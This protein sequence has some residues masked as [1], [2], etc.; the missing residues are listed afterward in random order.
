[1]FEK[2]KLINWKQPKFALP[3]I[4]YPLLLIA[5]FFILRFF[6]IEK[7]ETSVTVLETKD[8]LNTTLPEA[9]IKG[10]GV[11]DKFDAMMNEYGKISDLTAVD[12]I[13]REQASTASYE[14]KYTDAEAAVLENGSKEQKEALRQLRELRAQMEQQNNRSTGQGTGIADEMSEDEDAT[15]AELNDRLSGGTAVQEKPMTP[16]ERVRAAKAAKD[17]E[18]RAKMIAQN[19]DKV[20]IN[21]NA[22]TEINDQTAL[23]EVAKVEVP[24]SNHFNTIGKNEP[25]NRLI[26]AMVDEEI[27]V[28][29]GSRVRLKLL[30]DIEI[31]G[32][33]L[34]KGS[35]LYMLMSGF[36]QQRIKGTIKSV[37]FEDELVKVNLSIYDMDGMEGLYVPKSQ[38]REAAQQVGA[39]AFNSS[40]NLNNGGYSNSFSQWGRQTLQQASQKT[41]NT[42]SKIIKKNKVEIKYGTKVY[43]INSREKKEKTNDNPIQ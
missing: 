37:L 21:E 7:A 35:Y 8:E 3:G 23:E 31:S 17:A 41:M 33:T 11:P 18:R 20:V 9:N 14:S 10:T 15:L 26:M 25:G 38:F 43:L 12:N 39:G 32:R 29:Q 24:V 6:D 22:V 2:L 13:D 19:E 27:K 5:G 42:I 40:L 30:D 28:V 4:L 34:K 16:R 1:M 36:S